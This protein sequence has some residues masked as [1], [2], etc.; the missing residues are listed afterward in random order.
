MK[1]NKKEKPTISDFFNKDA[2]RKL[3]NHIRKTAYPKF[4][5]LDEL[6]KNSWAAAAG[7]RFG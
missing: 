1:K 6:R 3:C 4:K 5:A 2:Y 7:H